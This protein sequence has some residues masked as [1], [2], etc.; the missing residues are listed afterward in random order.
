MSRSRRA[1]VKS[2]TRAIWPVI[3]VVLVL[4]LGGMAVNLYL[5]GGAPKNILLMGVDED[6]TRT[7]VMVLAH[8]DPAQGLVNLISLPRDTL[9]E[10][11]CEGLEYCVSPDKLAHAHAYGGPEVAVQAAEK[12]LGITVDGYAR[13]DYNGFEKLVDAL[14]GVDIVIDKNMDYEDPYA[15]P[16]LNIHFRAGEQPQHLNGPDALRYVRYRND[17]LGDIGRTERT[18]QFFLALA[19]TMRSNGTIS[20]LPTLA[21]TLATHVDTNVDAGT[22]SALARAG[23]KVDPSAVQ[24][25]AVPG[26][27]GV[28]ESGAWVW[29]ADTEKLRAMVDE[30]VLHPHAV[31]TTA[32]GAPM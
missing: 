31:T 9:V 26:E 10:I 22:M 17:G 16:P 8:V 23:T 4:A 12:L 29:Q 5:G 25:A 3:F 20:K 30:L 13:I 24:M 19:E 27:P 21:A 1:P 2:G 14:G 18:R 32:G 15:K 28:T 11:P 6:K 7:D